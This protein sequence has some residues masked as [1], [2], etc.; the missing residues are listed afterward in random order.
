MSDRIDRIAALQALVRLTGDI[1]ANLTDLQTSASTVPHASVRLVRANLQ[2]AL[3]KFLSGSLSADLLE[4]WAEAVHG[5]EDIELDPSDEK[6]LA[7]ALFELS[8]PEFV[9]SMEQVVAG[10]RRQAEGLEDR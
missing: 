7:G 4:R 5:V 1:E 9:G 2:R 10:L 8:T 3:D 6:F